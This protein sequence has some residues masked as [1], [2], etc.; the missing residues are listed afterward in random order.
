MILAVFCNFSGTLLE[1]EKKM[2]KASRKKYT[3]VV[4]V[5][6]FLIGLCQYFIW[7]TSKIL[8]KLNSF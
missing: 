4:A 2:V 5:N 1:I 3:T 7:N 6:D 8:E